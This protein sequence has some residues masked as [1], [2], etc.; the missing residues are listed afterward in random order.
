MDVRVF[1]DYGAMSQ[2]AAELIIK[3]VKGKPNSVLGLATGSTPIGLYKALIE[4]HK[5]NGTTYKEVTTFNLDEYIGLSKDHNQSY[6]YFMRK[7]LF[8]AIDIDLNNV[9]IPDGKAEAIEEECARY[10]QLLAETTIDLQVLG[11]G[12]NGHIG[13]NEPGTPFDSV[14]QEVELTKET[15]EANAR[16]FDDINDVPTRAISMGIKNIL[17]AKQIVLLASGK[18]KAEAIRAM[19]KDPAHPDCPA[20]SLQNHNNV[21]VLLDEDAASLL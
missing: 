20:S 8:D 15:I 16:F 4:D 1:E 2:A 21:V 11:I 12:G 6:Y 17:D 7:T 19:I 9:E 3:Q 14:T 5:T 10:N 13:F 18:G